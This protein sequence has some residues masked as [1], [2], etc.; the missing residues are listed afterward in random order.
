MLSSNTR[1]CT[2]STIAVVIHS[3][4]PLECGTLDMSHSIDIE[5]SYGIS[6]VF[7]IRSVDRSLF[8]RLRDLYR[9]RYSL[10]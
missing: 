1:H 10:A 3:V 2:G 5:D 4:D 8:T 6:I 9:A 7:T